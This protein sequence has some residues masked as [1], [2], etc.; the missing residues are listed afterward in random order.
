MFCSLLLL[1][2]AACSPDETTV[3]I[4]RHPLIQG[5]FNSSIW[6]ANRY[7]FSAPVQVVAYPADTTQPGRLY[8]R[9]TLQAY[10]KDD[11]GN[12]LQFIMMFDAADVS[13]LA[14]VYHTLYTTTHGLAQVQIFNLK[15]NDLAAYALKAND[16]SA[17]LEIQRQSQSE[18]LIA[19]RFEM[20]LYNSRDS[21]QTITITHGTLTDINYRQ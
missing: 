20:T 17:F 5:L 21:T 2:L 19:G 15:N 13:Q 14:G 4:A 6:K 8:N 10:G 12:D 1:T 11:Q 16:T 7:T 3:G 18:R 9:M